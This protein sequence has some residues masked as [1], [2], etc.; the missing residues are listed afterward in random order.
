M[1]AFSDVAGVG[2]ICKGALEE[3]AIIFPLDK[4][5]LKLCMLRMSVYICVVWGV[6]MCVCMYVCL[7]VRMVRIS[8]CSDISLL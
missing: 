1:P 2:R 6:C 4:C 3:V 8:V 5:Y 7:C